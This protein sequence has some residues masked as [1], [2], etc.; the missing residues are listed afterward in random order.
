MVLA[1]LSLMLVVGGVIIMVTADPVSFGWFA[2][3]PLSTPWALAW[4]NR[5]VVGAAL[6]ALGLLLGAGVAGY[7]LGRRAP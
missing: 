1:V 6:A 2:Y 5:Q 3:A 4:T 7:H